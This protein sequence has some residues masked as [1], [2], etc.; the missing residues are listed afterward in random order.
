MPSRNL[1]LACISI[2][3]GLSGALRGQD[4]PISIHG[5]PEAVQRE[6]VSDFIA[7]GVPTGTGTWRGET[8]EWVFPFTSLVESFGW[9][10]ELV[11]ERLKQLRLETPVDEP[12]IL[13]LATTLFRCGCL[14]AY[15]T[16]E[17]DFKDHPKFEYFISQVI[18][19]DP[20]YAKSSRPYDVIYRALSSPDPRMQRKAAEVAAG[21]LAVNPQPKREE[22]WA[23]ALLRRYGRVPTE[24][25]LLTDPVAEAVRMRDPGLSLSILPRVLATAERRATEKPVP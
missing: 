10:Q 15:E 8:R 12:Q 11:A 21:F 24:A 20:L 16:F 22:A 7:R 4:R 13:R 3:L 23:D 1:L 5:Q 14:L 2:T 6:F 25:D 17:K 9:A 18:N 19:H